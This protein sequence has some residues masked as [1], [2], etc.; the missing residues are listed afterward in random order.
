MATFIML[1]R[2]S[3]EGMKTLKG[4]PER[5]QEVNREV[6]GFGA[7]VVQQ[8]ALLGEYDFITVLEAPDPETVSRV[9]VELSSRATAR[10]ETL[11]AIWGRP[12][13]NRHSRPTTKTLPVVEALKA[14]PVGR[15]GRLVGLADLPV[16]PKALPVGRVD[17]LGGQAGLLV[18]PRDHLVDRA[19]HLVDRADHPVGPKDHL[20]DQADLL[21]DPEDHLAKKRSGPGPPPRGQPQARGLIGS[22]HS[23]R[24]REGVFLETGAETNL[25]CHQWQSKKIGT[26]H[27]LHRAC[28]YRITKGSTARAVLSSGSSLRH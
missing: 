10:Y 15:A 5:L 4:N 11:T 12:M 1:S 16:D 20:G 2:L 19:D 3:P 24:W 28:R 18:G 13:R 6:E 27:T 21:A 7:R 8:Y 9:S 14:L 22:L 23:S 26:V 17:H 25:R